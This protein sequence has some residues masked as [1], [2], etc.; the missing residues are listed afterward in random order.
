MSELIKLEYGDLYK[1][2]LPEADCI[3]SPHIIMHYNLDNKK[4]ILQ[5]IF[6]ALHNN[7]DLIILENLVDENRS[8]DDC[9]MKISS[10][11]AMMGY[12]GFALSFTEFKD[13]LRSVGFTEVQ[14]IP[15]IPG[16]SDIIIARKMLDPEKSM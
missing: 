16:V 9:G 11:F 14:L 8:K 5:R 15:K 4:K 7:G 6:E 1:D 12:E 13:L 10:M 3:L 2:K